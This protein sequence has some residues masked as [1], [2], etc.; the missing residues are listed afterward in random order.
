MNMSIMPHTGVCMSCGH[1]HGNGIGLPRLPWSA[2]VAATL[3][4]APAPTEQAGLS[5]GCGLPL[6]PFTARS[7]KEDG[8]LYTTDDMQDYARAAYAMGRAS[9]VRDYVNLNDAALAAR[10]VAPAPTAKRE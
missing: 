10:Q 3:P 2:L 5:E 7:T 6:L 4:A 9:A 8:G 1:D